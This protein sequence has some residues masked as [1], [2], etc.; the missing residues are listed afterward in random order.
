MKIQIV[1]DLHLEFA[2]NRE[3][4]KQNPIIPVGDIL[5]IAG[6][7]YCL[8]HPE[9]ATEFFQKISED[10]PLIISTLGNHEYYGSN[11]EQANPIYRYYES[12]NHLVLNN[13]SFIYK[14]IRFICSV[15]WSFVPSYRLYDVQHG[16]NDYR[17]IY[18]INDGGN[19]YP[20]RVEDTNA[21]HELSYRF[22]E[23]AIAE[24]HDGPTILLTH[25][26]PSYKAIA[27]PYKGSRLS[28]AFAT[29]MDALIEA[30]PQI[31][32][33]FYGHAHDFHRMQINNCT[34][35]RNPLGYVDL[36]EQTDFRRDYVVE[37]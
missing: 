16:L 19:L 17:H 12:Y 8:N 24:K 3:W 6:D 36:H 32:Y 9:H 30:N 28:S 14:G 25:H 21:L 11:I 37:I 7:S 1:S 2:S 15:M 31:S 5:L 13:Q 10:F 18:K 35:I 27:P 4:I 23:Q 29:N 22:L 20:V 26:M 33:W 34:L